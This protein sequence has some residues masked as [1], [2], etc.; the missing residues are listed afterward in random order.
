MSYYKI[1]YLLAGPERSPLLIVD[2][3]YGRFESEIDLSAT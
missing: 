3:T 2:R 1:S